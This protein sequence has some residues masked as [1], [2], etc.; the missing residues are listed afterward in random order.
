MRV[1]IVLTSASAGFA[2]DAF[3]EVFYALTGAGA[4]VT[5]ASPDG[6]MPPADPATVHGS[7]VTR[8]RSDRDARNA[9]AD[10]LRLDQIVPEDFDAA[11]YPGGSGTAVDLA[12]NPL[13]HAILAALARDAKPI[14]VIG[15]G[16]AALFA[17]PLAFCPDASGAAGVVNRLLG[18]KC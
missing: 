1:L 15:E 4:E 17:G 7:A 16:V 2:F 11:V 3:A 6:G 10:T 12:G 5:L 14:G 13:S 9:L 18:V 8:F